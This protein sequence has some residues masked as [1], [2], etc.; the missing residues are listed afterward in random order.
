MLGG[1][2]GAPTKPEAEISTGEDMGIMLASAGHG[3]QASRSETFNVQVCFDRNR[4]FRGGLLSMKGTL[5]P[6]RKL[7]HFLTL[8]P[9]PMPCVSVAITIPQEPGSLRG[10]PSRAALP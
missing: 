4:S 8:A 9:V 2:D 6:L 7:R 1:R 3:T 5:M 10:N